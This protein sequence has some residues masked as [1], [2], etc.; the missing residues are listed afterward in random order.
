MLDVKKIQKLVEEM[1]REAF[2]EGRADALYTNHPTFHT[3]KQRSEMLNH[4]EIKEK[5]IGEIKHALKGTQE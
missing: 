1:E 5:I 3:A 4:K 2:Y